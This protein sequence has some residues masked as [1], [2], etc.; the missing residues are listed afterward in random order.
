MSTKRRLSCLKFSVL[1]TLIQSLTM[2]ILGGDQTFTFLILK[3]KK[4][5][6]IK[7]ILY[8]YI[9]LKGGA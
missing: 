8:K 3:I 5:I 7:Y 1:F 4:Y 9:F 2:W 6:N